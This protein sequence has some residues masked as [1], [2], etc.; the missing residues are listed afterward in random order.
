MALRCA[1]VPPGASPRSPCAKA[2]S[3]NPAHR[4]GTQNRQKRAPPPRPDL[5]L[6]TIRCHQT[7]V[8]GIGD[9]LI[10]FKANRWRLSNHNLRRLLANAN[11]LRVVSVLKVASC[12]RTDRTSDAHL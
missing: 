8:R 12:V 11:P 9:W 5:Q 3:P 7:R 4:Y 6:R 2:S 1:K 10:V